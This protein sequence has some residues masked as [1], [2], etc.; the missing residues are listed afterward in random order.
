MIATFESYQ[1]FHETDNC[2]K[3]NKNFLQNNNLSYN[4]LN[5]IKKKHL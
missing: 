4:P 5:V 3:N 2:G 1:I